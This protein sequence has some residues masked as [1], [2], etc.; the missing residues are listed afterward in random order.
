[1]TCARLELARVWTNWSLGEQPC[2]PQFSAVLGGLGSD[3]AP[4]GSGTG[5]PSCTPGFA[6]GKNSKS[7]SWEE[8]ERGVDESESS[9]Q[10]SSKV[11]ED[12]G[13]SM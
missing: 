2:S 7:E 13:G 12:E 3:A 8:L 4:F 11:D 6:E 10:G 9:K 5:S 1:M